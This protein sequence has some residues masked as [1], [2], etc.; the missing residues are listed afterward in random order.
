MRGNHGVQTRILAV[1]A[2]ALGFVALNELPGLPS[3]VL[4]WL[5]APR[6]PDLS[7]TPDGVLSCA[8][9]LAFTDGPLPPVPG[10]FRRLGGERRGYV[11]WERFRADAERRLGLPP[12]GADAP[13]RP[14]GRSGSLAYRNPT[15]IHGIAATINNPASTAAR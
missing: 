2:A 10:W 14:R 8:P 7:A 12:I 13:A 6:R 1:A 5:V 9:D 4:G 11:D 3:G 15:L